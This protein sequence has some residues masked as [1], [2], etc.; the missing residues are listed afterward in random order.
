MSE[1]NSVCFTCNNDL[2]CVKCVASK[3]HKNHEIKGLK[4]GVEYIS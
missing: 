2:L 3:Q 1:I 4:K